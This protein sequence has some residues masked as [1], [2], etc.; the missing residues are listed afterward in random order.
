VRSESSA[1]TSMPFR[2]LAGI[3][4]LPFGKLIAA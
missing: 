3:D 4:G 1:S 2:L